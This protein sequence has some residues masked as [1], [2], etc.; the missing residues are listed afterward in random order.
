MIK[1]SD[2]LFFKQNSQFYKKKLIYYKFI[3]FDFSNKQY[4]HYGDILFF[5]PLITFLS[6]KFKIK[7]K[8]FEEDIDFIK[9][10]LLDK[11]EIVT[12]IDDENYLTVTS[13]Y[14]IDLINSSNSQVGIGLFQN[15][16]SKP[17]P[18]VI[19]ETFCNFFLV[20]TSDNH[21]D[22]YYSIFLK[23]IRSKLCSVKSRTG[24]NNKNYFLVS[25][26]LGSGRFRDFF[27]I[28]RVQILKFARSYSLANNLIIAVV[29]SSTD[30]KIND[31]F[32]YIDLRGSNIIEI[33]SLVSTSNFVGGAGFDNFWMHYFDL[34]NKHYYVKFRGRF[35]SINRHN[36][37]NSINKSFFMNSKYQKDYI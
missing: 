23:K 13:P 11:I 37:Y 10:F 3:L 8:V 21:I 29:G 6:K 27:G 36:H 24:N 20:E 9:I 2:G 1:K 35:L 31:K 18:M 25:P 33:M 32:D 22:K 19:I 30:K 5:I 12:Y 28:K 7:I 16:Y 17:Y 26:Y 14:C 34:I 4:I 15:R